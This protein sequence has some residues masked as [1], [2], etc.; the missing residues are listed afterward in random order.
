MRAI[1]LILIIAVALL[2]AA[3]ASGLISFQQ[4][5]S[6][7]LP[8]IG[9]VENG[10][11]ARGGQAPAFDVETG[12]VAVGTQQR[13]LTV[14]VPTVEVTPADAQGNEAAVTRTE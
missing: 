14:A 2:I 4:T 9:T 12:T 1:L 10:V 3:I 11:S 7:K 5:R 13:N 8:D 6:A